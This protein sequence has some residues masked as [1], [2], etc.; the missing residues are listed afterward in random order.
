MELTQCLTKVRAQGRNCTSVCFVRTSWSKFT[1][2]HKELGNNESYFSSC[3]VYILPCSCFKEITFRY[4]L[5]VLYL[6][7]RNFYRT[8]TDVKVVVDASGL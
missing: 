8:K 3:F 6:V 4:N 1:V 2:I 5:V 7:W